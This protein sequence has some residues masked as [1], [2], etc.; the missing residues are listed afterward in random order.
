MR[1]LK[2]LVLAA[3]SC[4]PLAGSLEAQSASGSMKWMGVNGAWGSYNNTGTGGATWNVYTSPYRAQFAIPSDVPHDWHL[5]VNGGSGFGPT[6]DIFCV[7][8]NHYANTGTSHVFFTN[9]GTGPGFL[10]TYTRSNSLQKYLAAAY[11]AE[12]IKTNPGNAGI[13]SGAIWQIMSGQPN[14]WWNGHSWTSVAATA[15]YALNTGWHSVRADQWVVV[16]EGSTYTNRLGQAQVRLGSGQEYITHV[17][18]EPAT[19]LLLG[20]GLVVMLMAAG[21]FRRRTV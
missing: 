9:L 10:G 5:P 13:L 18:P 1:T 16:T 17:T 12:Q 6:E 2:V 20:T 3:T 21:V 15:S 14:Y 19:L 4:L 7:D 8:F 11:L